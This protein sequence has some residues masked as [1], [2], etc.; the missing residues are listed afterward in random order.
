[1]P[2]TAILARW[3]RCTTS[4]SGNEPG[5]GLADGRKLQAVQAEGVTV[6]LRVLAGDFYG[7]LVG[8]GPEIEIAE[9]DRPAWDHRRGVAVEGVWQEASVKQEM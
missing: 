8:T 1:M 2:T 5:L 9:L 6:G 4:T 7:E 3:W